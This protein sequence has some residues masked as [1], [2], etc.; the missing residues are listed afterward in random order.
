MTLL[1][2][3]KTVN[4]IEYKKC[5]SDN[6]IGDRYVLLERMTKRKN[7]KTPYGSNCL[8]CFNHYNK[9]YRSTDE[10]KRYNNIK[11]SEYA[12]TRRR[13][14]GIGWSIWHSAKNRA[15]RNNI[16]FTITAEDVIVPELCPILNIPLISDPD[17]IIKNNLKGQFN[18]PNYPSIDRIVPKLGYVKENII[19]ISWRA[20]NLKRDASLQELQFLVN[21]LSTNT[22]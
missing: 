19:V 9:A 12:R 1:S 7:R 21:W 5:I 16:L 4:G 13:N 15:K 3:I 2:D 11:A 10:Q 20:N 8:V 6:H 22:A 18:I 14:N 17:Y